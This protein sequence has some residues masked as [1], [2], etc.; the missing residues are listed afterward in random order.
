M[1]TLNKQKIKENI[2]ENQTRNKVKCGRV[3][4]YLGS[5]GV[6]SIF[7]TYNGSSK[8]FNDKITNKEGFLANK[9]SQDDKKHEF[10]RFNHYFE[11]K[12]GCF[13]T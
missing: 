9:N 1:E 12:K 3:A 8:A 11:G 7:N 6:K 2:I 5:S 10:K 4:D 13:M